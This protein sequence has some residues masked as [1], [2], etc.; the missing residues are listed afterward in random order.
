MNSQN[1]LPQ[2]QERLTTAKK[3]GKKSI[4]VDETK[5]LRR[6]RSLFGLL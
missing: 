3:E 6:N 5:S 4:A 2:A 1:L